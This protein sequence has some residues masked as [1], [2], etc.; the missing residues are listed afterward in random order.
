MS[1]NIIIN[2]SLNEEDEYSL[3][4]F[5]QIVESNIIFHLAYGILTYVVGSIGVFKKSY[6]V[7]RVF[8]VLLIIKFVYLIH[9]Y[10]DSNFPTDTI[11]ETILIFGPDWI[12]IVLAFILDFQ[13]RSDIYIM[14]D[15]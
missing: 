4:E 11:L 6:V 10:L 13:I 5:W 9:R 8:V 1:Y 7:L 3:E 2:P 12:S 14:N 15:F